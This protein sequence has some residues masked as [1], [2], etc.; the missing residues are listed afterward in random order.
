MSPYN[1]LNFYN[2]IVGAPTV[3]NEASSS[4]RGS[5]SSVNFGFGG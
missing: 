4:S 3:L 2:Q 5:S 1:A